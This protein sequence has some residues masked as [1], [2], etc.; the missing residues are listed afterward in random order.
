MPR[1]RTVEKPAP[2]SQQLMLRCLLKIK[3]RR[4]DQLRSQLVMLERQQQQLLGE[5]QDNQRRREALMEKLADLLA[6]QGIL[7]SGKLLNKK[8]RMGELFNQERKLATQQQAL[9]SALQQLEN[10]QKERRSELFSMM[11]NKEKIRM[12]LADEYY[13]S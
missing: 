13:Q 6:W 2:T 4:E 8:Q 3:D 10:Q 1:R 9:L 7:A 5:Q 12:I 11:K